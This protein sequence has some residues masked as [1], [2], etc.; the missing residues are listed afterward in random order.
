MHL[1]YLTV[2]WI[3][4][5]IYGALSFYFRP[6]KYWS[7]ND[8]FYL[9]QVLVGHVR[10]HKLGRRDEK[11][12]IWCLDLNAFILLTE[13]FISFSCIEETIWKI[14]GRIR[15]SDFQHW[16]MKA[17][18]SAV[19]F[20][21]IGRLKI[22][23]KSWMK[24]SPWVNLPFKSY[25]VFNI[26]NINRWIWN[27]TKWWNLPNKNTKSP[28]IAL[29]KYTVII[30]PIFEALFLTLVYSCFLNSSGD[31]YLWRSSETSGCPTAANFGWPSSVII[32][33]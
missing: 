3:L 6:S 19:Q 10:G 33:L 27:T 21:G 16:D 20:W 5:V 18:N 31:Q 15:G 11:L 17:Y 8:K 9:S 7:S 24:W 23:L 1:T 14:S 30:C 25:I 4:L 13:L 2:T 12:A 22:L 28:N 32:I 29:L 26:L